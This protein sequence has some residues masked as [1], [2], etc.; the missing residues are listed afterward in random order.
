MCQVKKNK[1]PALRINQTLINKKIVH[2]STFY[3]IC[4]FAV[5]PS[6][7][8]F[9]KT[10]DMQTKT[11]LDWKLGYFDHLPRIVTS[12]QFLKATVLLVLHFLSFFALKQFYCVSLQEKNNNIVLALPG[13]LPLSCPAHISYI[14]LQLSTNYHQYE[15]MCRYLRQ[16]LQL[17]SRRQCAS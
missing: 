5:I 4:R 14:H 6:A 13:L 7:P 8:C 11:S 3:R 1:L 9:S 2:T 12:V 15:P 17:K 10:E 16:A